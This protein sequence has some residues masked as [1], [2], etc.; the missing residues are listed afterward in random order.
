MESLLFSIDS[1]YWKKGWLITISAMGFQHK[2]TKTI[3]D[4]GADYL[5]AVKGN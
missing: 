3:I 4:K 2:I 5:I 1:I